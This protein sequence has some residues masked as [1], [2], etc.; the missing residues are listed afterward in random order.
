MKLLALTL[1][2]NACILFAVTQLDVETL[3]VTVP[4]IFVKKRKDEDK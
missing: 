3:K 2:V 4:I 1:F